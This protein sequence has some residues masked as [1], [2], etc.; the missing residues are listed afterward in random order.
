LAEEMKTFNNAEAVADAEN[1]I[2]NM[3]GEFS[4]TL[5]SLD[6]LIQSPATSGKEKE[7]LKIFQCHIVGIMFYVEALELKT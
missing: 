3:V 2:D 5:S 1:V 7:A 4:E 6:V